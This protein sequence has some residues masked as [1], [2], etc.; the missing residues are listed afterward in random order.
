MHEECAHESI[1]RTMAKG[2]D[3][4]ERRVI[5][6]KEN[7][8]IA[9][10]K[11]LILGLLLFMLLLNF[12]VAENQAFSP[13]P[14]QPYIRIKVVDA[15]TEEPIQNASIILWNLGK[16]TDKRGLFFTD[17]EGEYHYD[18][19]VTGSVYWIY[20]YKGN[21]TTGSIEYAPSKVEVELSLLETS[22][23]VTFRLVP[24]ATV[25]LT[26][27]I[28]AAEVSAFPRVFRTYIIDPTSGGPPLLN[29]SFVSTYDSTERYYLKEKDF[30]E[31]KFVFIPAGVS[32]DLEFTAT[33]WTRKEGLFRRSFRIRDILLNK[34]EQATFSL[35]YYSLDKSV[36]TIR[37]LINT[38]NTELD[39]AQNAGFYLAA[40]R[41]KLRE[42]TDAIISAQ[43]KLE[44]GNYYQSWRLLSEAY[45]ETLN[46]RKTLSYYVLASASNAI[47]LPAFFAV[48]S[49]ILASFVFENNR[50]KIISSLIFY[51]VF[52]ALLFQVYPGTRIIVNKN[53]QLFAAAAS[54]SIA[55]SLGAVFGLPRYWK[56]KFEGAFRLR[57]V[58]AALFS[59]GKRQ[60]KI[61]KTR[62]FLTL[63]S[64]VILVLAFTSLTSF[65]VVYDITTERLQYSPT[66][67]GIL[68]KDATNETFTDGQ[69]TYFLFMPF[70]VG[71]YQ[72]LLEDPLV[73]NVAPKIETYPSVNPVA[74]LVSDKGKL[75]IFGVVGIKPEEESAFTALNEIIEEGEYLV[76]QDVNSILISKSAATDLNLQPGKTVKFLANG[77]ILNC[78]VK[79]IFSDSGY[80]Q[81]TEIDGEPFGPKRAISEE[82]GLTF[83]VCDAKNVVIMNFET[84]IKLQRQINVRNKKDPDEL[85]T[86]NILSRIAFKRVNGAGIGNIIDTVVKS[87]NKDVYVSKDGRVIRYFIG[88]Y[89]EAKG[90][91]EL[92]FPL[93][94]TGLNVGAVMLNA[95]YERRRE[96]KILTVIGS[97]PAHLAML[98]I[99]EA[100]ILGMV[101][102][103]LGYLF[104][105]GFYRIMPLIGTGL[106]VREKLEWWWSAL[107]FGLA[108]LASVIST[109]RPALLAVKMYTP[110]KVRKAK[111]SEEEK[112]AR[113][114]EIFRIYQE[115][116]LSLPV[117]V[118]KDDTIFFI[119]FLINRLEDWSTGIYERITDISEQPEMQ[120]SKGRIIKR[121]EFNYINTSA[122]RKVELKNEVICS[123]D[124]D[125]D[126][127]RVHL[128]LNLDNV[129]VSEDWI[130]RIAGIVRDITLDWTKNRDRIVGA[131]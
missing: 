120:T 7:S 131:V 126:Y 31:K 78:T 41:E 18:D 23:N 63:S 116:R 86:F 99:S 9:N 91:L 81:L 105:L 87:Y 69:N 60:I 71:Y 124:S 101:G 83:K 49:V 121:I 59:L 114:E 93:A 111:V 89:Y 61:R 113:K 73:K 128:A 88:K 34:R 1:D 2:I 8:Y 12:G 28:R 123:K 102:G 112:K 47:Y 50:R 119:N 17:S 106:I 62:G 109:L 29:G 53:S 107:G 20:A 56:S 98:F 72:N 3:T 30:L 11:V 76:E 74:Y 42:Q 58:L 70:G 127:Y 13:N 118:H 84:S 103:G 108:I 39:E 110:S 19:A 96:M 24:A 32:V 37:Q 122:D 4:Q 44:E 15:N 14:Q 16:A 104:G 33:F 75:E 22:K 100:V 46:V 115:R 45:T 48:Y 6:I 85:G 43:K 57:N 129:E 92:L 77:I 51:V 5:H 97:N 55:A 95:V 130:Y 79:G 82:E 25:R 26:G 68:M 36:D 52:V 27:E 90:G 21:L 67:E 65:G 64:L 117:K 38:V 40:E 94:M 80:E 54:L 10:L 125:E 35:D 66:V